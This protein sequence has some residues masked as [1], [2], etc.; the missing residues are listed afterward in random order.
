MW[1]Q[2]FVVRDAKEQDELGGWQPEI[3][4]RNQRRIWNQGGVK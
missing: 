3:D 1:D 2:R 4:I